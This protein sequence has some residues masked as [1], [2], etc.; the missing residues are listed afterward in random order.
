MSTTPEPV[1]PTAA[2]SD[3]PPGRPA[4]R[5]RLWPGPLGWVAVVAFAAVLGVAFVPVD[6]LLALVVGAIALLGGLAGAVLTTPRVEVERGE[7]HAGT[8]RIPV[9]LLAAP[10]VL[11]RESLRT[12][13]G[14]AL[15]A[16]AYVCLR[17]WIGTA[18][19]VEVRDP[20]DPTPYWI[21]STRRPHDLVVALGGRAASA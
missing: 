3:A 4:F 18:V 16:R 17:A 13:L 15:D 7:L 19:R 8:A 5:E 9:R 2:T 6:T 10:R 14:P 21:V 20:Q 11:D 1:T 12:E